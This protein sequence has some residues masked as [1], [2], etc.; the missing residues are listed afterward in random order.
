MGDFL[1]NG[2]CDGMSCTKESRRIDRLVENR[3]KRPPEAR[4]SDKNTANTQQVRFFKLYF[5]FNVCSAENRRLFWIEF[6]LHTNSH[7]T[8]WLPVD[9]RYVST[10]FSFDAR[11]K[12]INDEFDELNLSFLSRVPGKCDNKCRLFEEYV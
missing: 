6:Q 1:L 11:E 5:D 3:P 2:R 12:A 7:I 9:F 10:C 8:L 4:K